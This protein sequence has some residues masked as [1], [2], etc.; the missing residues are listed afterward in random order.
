MFQRK[1][2]ETIMQKLAVSTGAP[3]EA[4]AAS[5]F[6]EIV[7]TAA[8]YSKAVAQVIEC[9]IAEDVLEPGRAEKTTPD[10]D[11]RILAHI[12]KVLLNH[13]QLNVNENHGCVWGFSTSFC[14]S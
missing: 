13:G 3:A 2:Q 10:P 8:I 9:L 11:A 4:L 1:S 6:T 7:A 12:R 5:I 14:C